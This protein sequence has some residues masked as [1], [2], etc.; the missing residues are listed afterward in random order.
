MPVVKIEK[1]YFGGEPV[2]LKVKCNS[3]GEFSADRHFDWRLHGDQ[4]TG[5]L[6]WTKER[7][8]FFAKIGRSMEHVILQLKQLS[9]PKRALEIADKGRLLEFK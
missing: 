6:P 4:A 7:Q 2:E 3:D 8:E 9:D 5:R 1:R